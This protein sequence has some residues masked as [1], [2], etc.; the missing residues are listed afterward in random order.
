MGLS[1]SYGSWI[2]NYLCNQCLSVS[3]LTWD[4]TP[5]MQGVLDTTS[6]DK[7]CQWLAAGRWF[8]P[9][10]PVSAINKTDHQNITEILLKVA[11]KHPIPYPYLVRVIWAIAISLRPLF[12]SFFPHFY[13]ISDLLRSLLHPL[14]QGFFPFS[15]H[16]TLWIK[17]FFSQ[18]LDF[19]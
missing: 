17:Y 14:F 11:F 1:W 8:S 13:L 16:L 15:A 10:T 18:R 3:P 19:I 4:R 2:Y 6:C 12:Q 9:G 7:V 5:L